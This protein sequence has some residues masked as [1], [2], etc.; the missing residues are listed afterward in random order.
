M[1]HITRA[2]STPDVGTARNRV[3]KS[4]TFDGGAG[5]GAV[6]TVALFT[7]TG[8]VYIDRFT[9]FCTTVLGGTAG[10]SAGFANDVDGLTT[11]IT[12]GNWAAGEFWGSGNVQP[13]SMNMP[14]PTAG[15]QNGGFPLDK[16]VSEN[17]ILTIT[18]S[19]VASGAATF[20]VW[21]TP[22]SDGATITAA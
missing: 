1:A 18:T 11:I 19:A 2:G 16:A 12:S 9:A 10:V 21:Y 15:G 8:Q 4:V 20:D 13:G 22:I 3:R 17:I 6:G 7:V 5:S 14:R